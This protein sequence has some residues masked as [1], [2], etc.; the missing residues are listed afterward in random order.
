MEALQE[1]VRRAAREATRSSVHHA[2]VYRQ[3][4]PLLPNL[5]AMLFHAVV[6][7]GRRRRTGAS[8]ITVALTDDSVVLL[9][10]KVRQARM[11]AR[12]RI[13]ELSLDSIRCR[14]LGEQPFAFELEGADGERW[15]LFPKW[16]TP[17]AVAI[18]KRLC[19]AG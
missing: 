3:T 8:M 7:L 18:S 16:D 15:Q 5:P 10:T 17:D 4:G 6:A 13:A 2:A 1:S 11:T 19:A 14:P 9:D 12:R